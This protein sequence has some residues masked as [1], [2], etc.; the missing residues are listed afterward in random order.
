MHYGQMEKSNIKYN[1]GKSSVSINSE[2]NEIDIAEIAKD[3]LNSKHH[4][5]ELDTYV[6][7]IF[8]SANLNSEEDPA[9]ELNEM[10]NTVDNIHVSIITNLDTYKDTGYII[11]M[12]NNSGGTIINT[13]NSDAQSD[14]AVATFIEKYLRATEQPLKIISSV[15]LT[16]LSPK[17]DRNYITTLFEDDDNQS[18]TD[19]DGLFDRE[20][21]AFDSGLIDLTDSDYLPSVQD[22]VDYL[23]VT[24]GKYTYVVDG[25]DDFLNNENEKYS[26]DEYDHTRYA[27]VGSVRILPINSDPTMEDGDDD[28]ILDIYEFEC[29][30]TNPLNNDTDGDKLSDG[31]E[32]DNWFDPLDKNPDGDSYN[33]DYEFYNS[34]DSYTYDQSET[35]WKDGFLRGLILGDYSESNS[36][37]TLLGQIVGGVTPGVGTLGDIRDIGANVSKNDS[38]G[39]IFSSIGL[40]PGMGDL[41]KS[42]ATVATFIGKNADDAPLLVKTFIKVTK[43]SPD[44]LKSLPTS[45]FDD[46]ASSLKKGG[47]ITKADYSELRKLFSDS[48]KNLDELVHGTKSM[49]DIINSAISG[50]R[51]KGS[52]KIIQ[53]L[54]GD[55]ES[56]LSDFYCLNPLNIK[57][58]P[59]SNYAGFHGVLP[60][61]ID[62]TVRAGSKIDQR[63]TLQFYNKATGRGYE[64]RYGKQ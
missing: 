38:L 42:A 57:P 22:C 51:S 55:Y 18:D 49:D 3:A 33:D 39:V 44:I 31:E 52:C 12:V 63:P 10:V 8:N 17:F 32:I 2:N 36:V 48:G 27:L 25:Y 35:E 64:I 24:T 16:P 61:G 11:E 19:F 56:A 7:L 6:F 37:P 47:S 4:I 1:V 54:D 34:T 41:G 46:I 14:M 40:F 21:I 28:G 23:H 5:E 58:L 30:F 60:N 29:Y 59:N 50:Y 43:D 53:K 45:A 9:R 15:G 62:V 13:N 20:E 26:S